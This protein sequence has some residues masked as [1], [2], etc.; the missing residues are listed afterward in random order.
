MDAES[1]KHIPNLERLEQAARNTFWDYLG[2]R[3]DEIDDQMATVSF[4]IQPHHL[5]L[6]GILHGGVHAAVIDSAMGLILM[7]AR[8]ESSIVTINLN[9]NYVAPTQQGRVIVTAKIIHS[10]RRIMTA[11]AYA[12]KENGDLLAF[13]TGTFRVLDRPVGED[14]PPVGNEHG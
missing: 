3:I 5:N 6:I 8:P 4:D 2:C 11:E 13:G 9:M 14:H 7:L 10:T 12:R 1:K